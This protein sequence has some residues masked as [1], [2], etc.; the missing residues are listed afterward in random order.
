MRL[1]R[2]IQRRHRF[3]GHHEPWM[4]HQSARDCDPLPLAPG[5]HV[6]V[7]AIVLRPQADLGHHRPHCIAARRGNEVRVDLQR[8][9][10]QAT[11]LLAR[12]ERGIGIL[13]HHLHQGAQALPRRRVGTHHVFANEL[14]LTG[15]RPL[16]HRYLSRERRLAAAGFAD[17]SQGFAFVH[18]KRDAIERAHQSFRLE[19]SA[20]DCVVTRQSMRLEERRRCHYSATNSGFGSSRHPCVGCPCASSAKWQRACR[21][22]GPA[23]AGCSRRQR[24]TA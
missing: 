10:Q 12:V 21:P 11:D 17:D 16:D 4:Q 22:T 1:D 7:A 5:K 23:S 19:Q 8:L 9:L 14:E 20:R 24:S 13:E 3:I 6:W 18:G 2:H 15:R